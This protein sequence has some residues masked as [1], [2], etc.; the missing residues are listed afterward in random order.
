MNDLINYDPC[1][2]RDRIP[3]PFC[4]IEPYPDTADIVIVGSERSVRDRLRILVAGA[5][6][7]RAA[8]AEIC[9]VPVCIGAV[10]VVLSAFSC[11]EGAFDRRRARITGRAGLIRRAVPTA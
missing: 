7:D 1:V 5:G 2:I 4:R 3:K 6:P 8:A 10:A 11:V 9:E